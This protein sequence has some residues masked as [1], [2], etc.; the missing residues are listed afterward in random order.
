MKSFENIVIRILEVMT[1]T[2][3]ILLVLFTA[4]QVIFRSIGISAP[5]TEEMARFC[6][7]YITFFGSILLIKEKGHI[8]VDFLLN[9]LSKNKRRIMNII[10][11]LIILLFLAIAIFGGINTIKV[12]SVV[13]AASLKWFKM[14]YVYGGVFLGLILMF[15]FQIESLIKHILM[16]ETGGVS[17][18]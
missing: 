18:D 2:I 5:W 6:Y 17:N 11:D 9:H 1:T 7:I 3:L 14:N 13:S 16:H 12:N 8:V 10:I 4:C 15:I